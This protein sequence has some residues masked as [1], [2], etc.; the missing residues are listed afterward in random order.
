MRRRRSR[1][2]RLASEGTVEIKVWGFR[3]RCYIVRSLFG[4][5]VL[6]IATKESRL[7][8]RISEGIV[9]IKVWV[10]GGGVLNFGGGLRIPQ[11]ICVEAGLV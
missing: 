10:L 1:L 6:R 8:R 9:E 3:V 5:V 2:G 7:G 11:G 4:S